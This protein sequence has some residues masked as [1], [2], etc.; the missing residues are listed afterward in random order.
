MTYQIL[1][2]KKL[3]DATGVDTSNL[4]VKKDFITLKAEDNDLDV[5]KLVNFPTG[6][7]NINLK[8]II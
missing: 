1:L 8:L 4:A 5:N 7:N 6:L 3:K 2:L